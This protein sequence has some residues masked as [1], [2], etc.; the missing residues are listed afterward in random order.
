MLIMKFIG[1]W[2]ASLAETLTVITVILL[3]IINYVPDR[4][5][6]L[7]RDENKEKT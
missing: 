6:W 7:V 1:T 2:D 3:F 4:S 5:D